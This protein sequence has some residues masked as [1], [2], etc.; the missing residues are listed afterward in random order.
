VQQAVLEVV[1]PA[2][3]SSTAEEVLGL[4][5]SLQRAKAY[6]KETVDEAKRKSLVA[7][8]LDKAGSVRREKEARDDCRLFERYM[9]VRVGWLHAG[10]LVPAVGNRQ[11]HLF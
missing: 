10:S 8:L 2:T 9:K 3:R 6:N 11:R 1:P 7:N 4:L 5:N